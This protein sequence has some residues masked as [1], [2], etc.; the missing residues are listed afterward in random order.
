MVNLP[1]FKRGNRKGRSGAQ[2]PGML[3]IESCEHVRADDDTTLVRLH[4]EPTGALDLD[5]LTLISRGAAGEGE[6]ALLAPPARVDGGE[7]RQLV[8][9]V[10][11]AVAAD[12][13]IRFEVSERG[14][15]VA[16]LRR[17]PGRDEVA[18]LRARLERERLSR[19]EADEELG[20][21]SQEL[22]DA[23]ALVEQLER[24]CGISERNLTELRQKLLL[25]WT[26]STELRQ[27]LEDREEA[28][29]ASKKEAQRLRD[30]ERELTEAQAAAEQLEEERARNGLL[31]GMADSALEAFQRARSETDKAHAELEELR[32][33][34]GGHEQRIAELETSERKLGKELSDARVALEL[35]QSGKR[36]QLRKALQE[37]E[38]ERLRLESELTGLLFRMDDLEVSAEKTNGAAPTA[39]AGA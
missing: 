12:E 4:A 21:R 23:R 28:H 38:A 24:R 37:A 2:A 1:A 10:P 19:I 14:R 30:V 7:S 17:V 16:K 32:A 27:L 26:E 31:Q 15:V 33:E 8:F 34:R 25:A 20:N 36:G 6:H 39:V 9:A 22:A 13:S 29:Q 11:T 35:A 3:R 5:S 18:D